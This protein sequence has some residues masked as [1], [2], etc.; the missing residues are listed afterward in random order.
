MSATNRQLIALRIRRKT[1]GQNLQAPEVADLLDWF[2][3]AQ[4]CDIL[5]PTNQPHITHENIAVF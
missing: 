3:D 5:L 2:P 1:G 4:N